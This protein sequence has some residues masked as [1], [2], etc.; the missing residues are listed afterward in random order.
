MYLF[1]TLNN[2]ML[3]SAFDINIVDIESIFEE[4]PGR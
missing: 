4:Q 3:E 1:P 2:R